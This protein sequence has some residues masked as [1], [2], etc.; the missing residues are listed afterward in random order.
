MLWSQFSAV[1]AKFRRKN[2]VYLNKQ[3]CDVNFAKIS[4]ILNKKLQFFRQFFRRKYFKNHN[5]DP[6]PALC[7]FLLHRMDCHGCW[8]RNPGSFGLIIFYHPPQRLPR[9]PLFFVCF[10][11]E[12]ACSFFVVR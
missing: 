8:G 1:F 4:S 2:G 3:C 12:I 7:N 10:V 9:I 11:S 5:I 6:W